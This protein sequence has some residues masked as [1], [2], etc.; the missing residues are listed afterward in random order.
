MEELLDVYDKLGNHAG[1]YPRREC[2]GNP[3]LIHRVV[4]VVVFDRELKHILLQKRSKNKT[5]QPGKW[6][7]AV[8]GHVNAG[9]ELSA[10]ACRELREE[11]GIDS[12]LEFFFEDKIRNEIESE[13]VF[14]YKTV[15]DGPFDYQREEIDAVEF[16]DLRKF[17][18]PTCRCREDFTPNLQKEL[19]LILEK[20]GIAVK[21]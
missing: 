19:A 9:E 21:Q 8:G 11:L 7:T 15:S 18:D 16:F 4:H 17:A 14:V 2:H 3:A 10:A 6:D 20:M 13:D 5:I 12:P 1:C